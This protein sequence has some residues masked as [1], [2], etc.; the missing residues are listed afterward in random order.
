MWLMLVFQLSG[1]GELVYVMEWIHRC[2]VYEE[3]ESW[4]LGMVGV[5]SSGEHESGVMVKIYEARLLWK[6]EG[7]FDKRN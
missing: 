5:N 3:C 1:L 7:I 6:K 4:F 2:C